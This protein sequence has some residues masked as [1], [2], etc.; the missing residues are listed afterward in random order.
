VSVRALTVQIAEEVKVLLNAGSTNGAFSRTFTAE[1]KYIPRQKLEDLSVLTLTVVP[2]AADLAFLSRDMEE[3]DH[4][5]DVGVQKRLAKPE[6]LAEI[7]LLTAFV[8]E[9]STHLVEDDDQGNS[10]RI[11]PSG[12]ALVRLQ[13]NPIFLPDHLRDEQCFTA[14]LTLTY[15]LAR[16]FR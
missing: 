12:A 10:R 1:R 4:A 6:D 9:L 5:V 11:L 14:V 15:H 7:D 8:E 2:V 3:G 13:N 16:P